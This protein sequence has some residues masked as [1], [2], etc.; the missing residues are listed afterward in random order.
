MPITITVIASAT[1]TI[2]PIAKSLC[3]QIQGYRK[4]SKEIDNLA[5]RIQLGLYRLS[6]C[7]IDQIR[8]GS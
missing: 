5:K 4:D 1:K 8:F 2:L 6:G 3:D 7:A